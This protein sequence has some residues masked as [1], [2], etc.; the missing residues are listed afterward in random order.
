M[1]SRDQVPKCLLVDLQ[2][3]EGPPVARLDMQYRAIRVHEN[4][5]RD[6]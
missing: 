4:I 1:D 5:N 3:V 6:L 2:P